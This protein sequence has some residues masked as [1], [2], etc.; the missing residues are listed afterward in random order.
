MN[1]HFAL[2]A[3]SKQAVQSGHGP[4]G[5]CGWTLQGEELFTAL[6]LSHLPEAPPCSCMYLLGTQGALVSSLVLPQDGS[7]IVQKSK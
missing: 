1:R 4:P 2:C 6:V 7:E 5:L 3:L